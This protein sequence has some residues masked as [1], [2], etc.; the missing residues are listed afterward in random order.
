MKFTYAYRTSDNV[1]HE[2]VI[3]APTKEAAYAALKA[4]GIKPGRVVEAPGFFNKLFGKGKRWIAIGVLGAVCLALCA[5]VLRTG[6]EDLGPVSEAKPLPR[7]EIS[8]SR[9]RIERAASESF[10][11]RAEAFLA[12]FAEPGRKADAPETDWPSK[13][14]FEAAFAHA[15]T[16]G[17]NE[18]TEQIDLKRIVV[19]MKREAKNYIRSGGYV[20]GYIREL[21]ARQRKEIAEREKGRSRLEELVAVID[22]SDPK[23]TSERAAYDF[24]MKENARLHSMGIH[25]LDLPLKL[26]AIQAAGGA[27]E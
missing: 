15:I 26:T 8:G 12:R 16:F 10:P 2:G 20:S 24:W 23:R 17:E 27:V 5:V 14:E 9:A 3:C 21:V 7:Q 11:L 25:P 22:A 13:A 19:W 6:E 1:Q 4:Q 18:W